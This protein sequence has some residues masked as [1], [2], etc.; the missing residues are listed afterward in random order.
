[1]IKDGLVPPLPAAPTRRPFDRIV[2]SWDTANKPSELADYSVCTTWGLK[3]PNFY[4]LNVFRKKLA[5]PE[6][7]RAVVEQDELFRP[8]AILIEDKASGTQLI[9]DLI[10]DGLSKVDALYARTAT[11]SCACTRRPRRS[12]TASSG[13][14]RRRPGS[15]TTCA[16][17]PPS[18]RA[19]TTTRSNSTAQ[20]L[21]WPKR[22][23]DDGDD[24]LLGGAVRRRLR[25]RRSR[26]GRG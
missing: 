12:R 10:G 17:S 2:Q 8:Q 13:C 3:G 25:R 18:R 19:A 1:M 26:R 7:K 20:A 14:R 23:V 22:P 11:R 21:A 5:Y 4:L 15:P 9:Q 16:S 24:R 6:L